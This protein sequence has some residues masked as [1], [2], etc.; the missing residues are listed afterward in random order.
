MGH[1]RKSKGQKIK[2]ATARLC[3]EIE[4]KQVWLTA[5]TDVMENLLAKIH[6]SIHDTSDQIKKVLLTMENVSY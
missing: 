3:A 1:A 2:G 4:G 6:L 5:F